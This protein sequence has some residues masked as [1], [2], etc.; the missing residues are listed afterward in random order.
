[1]TKKYK[2][3]SKQRFRKTKR[4]TGGAG[5][6]GFDLDFGP[7]Y[8]SNGDIIPFL[9]DAA[10]GV[11]S[12]TDNPNITN[13]NGSTAL[14]LAADKGDASVVGQLLTDVRVDPNIDN[15]NVNTALILAAYAG[16]ASVVK[17]LLAD[18][19]VNPNLVDENGETALILAAYAG[20]ASVV[21]LLLKNPE[22]DPNIRNT[23]GETAL[24]RAAY[25]GHAPVV[26]LLLAH[27]GV[28]PNIVDRQGNIEW[29][30][31]AWAANQNKSD[32]LE[33][34]LEDPRTTRT[35]PP[36]NKPDDQSAYDAALHAVKKRRNNKFKG[37]I[38]SIPILKN[39]RLNAAK[40]TYAPGG[41]GF[42]RAA[43]SFATIAAEY[44]NV[45]PPP[46]KKK[47][48]WSSSSSSSGTK[49]KKKKKKKRE[50]GTKRQGSR[51]KR[52]KRS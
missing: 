45:P 1:M 27:P 3:K 33:I 51:P 36:D 31:L 34:L 35:R 2:Q 29:T 8:N 50:K 32:V 12:P 22:T 6:D 37:L 19:R 24:M 38:R 41:E 18:D 26:T 43:E 5:F 13:W 4:K 44:N 28:D 21:K 14:I 48:K 15:N 20:H 49:K 25:E 23:D 11:V 47:S 30:A 7:T 42:N 46:P 17:L 39:W 52:K 10:E 9:Q 40:A 16:H